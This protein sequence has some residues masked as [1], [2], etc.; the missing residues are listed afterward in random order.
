M[1]LITGGPLLE[2]FIM[3]GGEGLKVAGREDF[4]P[5]DP[6]ISDLMSSE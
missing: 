2:N 5:E 3:D 4:E 6:E 1:G